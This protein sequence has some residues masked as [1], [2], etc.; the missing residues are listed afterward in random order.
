MGR[1]RLLAVLLVAGLAL[2]A[3]AAASA[4]APP[5]DDFANAKPLSGDHVSEEG[6]TA[7]ATFEVGTEPPHGGSSGP[8]VWYSWTA[9]RSGLIRLGCSDSYATVVAVYRGSSLAGLTEVGTYRSGAQCPNFADFSFRAVGGAEYRIAVVASGAGDGAFTLTLDNNSEVPPNDDFANRGAMKDLGGNALAFGTTEGASREVGEPA[10]GGSSTGASV[11]Y[12]WTAQRSGPTTVYFCNGSFHPVIDVY[13]GAALGALTSLG[14]PSPGASSLDLMCSLGN[15]AGTVFPALAGQTYA[16]AVDGANGDWGSFEL[17]LRE[18]P[19]PRVPQPPDTL[20]YKT[21]KIRG[22]TAKIHFAAR[23][24]I[25][26]RY[27][28]KLDR[29]PFRRCGSPKTYRGLSPGRHRFAVAAVALD[30]FGER[31]PSP[32]VRHFRIPRPKAGK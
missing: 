26:A 24:G 5:N 17:R 19:P 12:T 20:I 13:A 23:R 4:A 15:A 21:M 31:D 25:E 18:A 32:A 22:N 27:F 11:W 8:S 6:T 16:I 2:A 10:H 3:P 7:E 1:G 29:R 28:C 30:A 9:P 14:A